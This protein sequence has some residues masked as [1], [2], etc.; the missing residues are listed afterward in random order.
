MG[1]SMNIINTEIPGE[2]IPLQSAKSL[3]NRN[4][5]QGRPAG[6]TWPAVGGTPASPWA[7]TWASGAGTVIPTEGGALDAVTSNL[8]M[9]AILGVGG[10]FAY[11]LI[12][13]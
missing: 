4:A 7:Q 12:K 10:Y 6:W 11:K 1:M 2:V 5:W 13:K 3:F 9:L 8:P